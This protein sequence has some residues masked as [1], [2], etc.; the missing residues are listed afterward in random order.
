M[1][2]SSFNLFTVYEDVDKYIG[3]LAEG[4][5]NF[6]VLT[7]ARFG[8]GG[9]NKVACLDLFNRL[10]SVFGK[11]GCSCNKTRCSAFN[12]NRSIES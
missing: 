5:D 12:A 11:Y 4:A 8:V 10:F 2:G 3:F 1:G 9:V 6:L 7:F